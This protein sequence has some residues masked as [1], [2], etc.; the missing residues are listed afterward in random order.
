MKKMLSI[1]VVMAMLLSIAMLSVGCAEEQEPEFT[2]GERPTEATEPT[3]EGE[4]G[5]GA[6]GQQSEGGEGGGDSSG[7]GESS[8]PVAKPEMVGNVVHKYYV[9]M[10]VSG[11][12]GGMSTLEIYIEL[13]DEA[14]ADGMKVIM[15][16]NNGGSVSY[17][18]YDNWTENEDGTITIRKDEFSTIDTKLIDG[19]YYF[20]GVP[21]SAGMGSNGN[22]DIPEMP[23]SFETPDFG[24]DAEATEPVEGGEAPAE[25]GEGSEGAEPTEAPAEGETPAEGESEGGESEGGEAPAE[26]ETPAEGEATEA[27]A[28]GESEGGES[29][30]GESEGGEAPAEG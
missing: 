12:L 11:S 29:E 17:A 3:V 22:V 10:E 1:L 30:G 5:E 16:T 21:Y 9:T 23:L 24:G 19:T 20:V 25:G 2:I 14:N 4:G 28:E 15:G 18:T 7:G 26:G 13:Y 8:T 6:E 27:P